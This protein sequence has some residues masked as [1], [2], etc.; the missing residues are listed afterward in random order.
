MFTRGLPDG[1]Q[2]TMEMTEE[3]KRNVMEAREIYITKVGM[4]LLER[5]EIKQQLQVSCG[6]RTNLAF[7]MPVVPTALLALN[8]HQRLLAP[9]YLHDCLE[10]RTDG[11][12]ELEVIPKTVESFR[13]PAIHLEWTDLASRLKVNLDKV[14]RCNAYFM[15][16]LWYR[17]V[18]PA[19]LTSSPN[20]TSA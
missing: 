20:C 4:M 16:R 10:Q 12:Q 11:V 15:S 14:H 2:D 8:D 17:D 13:V 3:Q 5:H 9:K 6:C 18:S 7:A 1:M 19:P